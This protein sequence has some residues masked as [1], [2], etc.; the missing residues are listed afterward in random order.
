MGA[1]ARDRELEQLGPDLMG[2]EAEP[3]AWCV[4]SGPTWAG[5]WPHP[6]PLTNL[7]S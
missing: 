1:E 6:P 4:G 5:S 7:S 2:E 3:C